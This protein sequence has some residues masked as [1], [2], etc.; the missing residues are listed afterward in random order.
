MDDNAELVCPWEALESVAP[1]S[2]CRFLSLV[3][4]LCCA[5][6]LNGPSGCVL[7]FSCQRRRDL[8]VLR[9]V[10]ANRLIYCVHSRVFKKVYRAGCEK[11]E[12]S[13]NQVTSGPVEPLGN[14]VLLVHADRSQKALVALVLC[15]SWAQTAA[16]TLT[17]FLIAVATGS[18]SALFL[19]KSY[20]SCQVTSDCQKRFGVGHV[21]SIS[22]QQAN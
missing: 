22:S 1:L 19:I 7:L 12:A 14:S 18:S 3:C 17:Q 11:V 5:L 10:F 16:S 8:I 4:D 21:N 2:F 13:S 15:C 9:A 6:E 20:W